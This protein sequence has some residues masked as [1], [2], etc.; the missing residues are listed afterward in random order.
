MEDARNIATLTVDIEDGTLAI[1]DKSPGEGGFTLLPAGVLA[2]YHLHIS[3]L[4][5]G[6]GDIETMPPAK[7][8]KVTVLVVGNKYSIADLSIP[9]GTSITHIGLLYAGLAIAEGM[10]EVMLEEAEEEVLAE[11]ADGPL[12]TAQGWTG[13]PKEVEA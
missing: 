5:E 4:D 2:M 10:I 3:E 9:E 6:I 7:E 1:E 11:H 12:A 8:V 13:G